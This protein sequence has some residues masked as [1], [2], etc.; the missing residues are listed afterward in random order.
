MKITLNDHG[1]SLCR[2]QLP[3]LIGRSKVKAVDIILRYKLE[4]NARVAETQT[5]ETMGLG[6]KP[7]RG[8]PVSWRECP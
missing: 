2:K 1:V 3:P 8:T 4:A 7:L 5:P 6:C